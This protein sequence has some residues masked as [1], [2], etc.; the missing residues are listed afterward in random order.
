MNDDQKKAF[1]DYLTEHPE[2]FEEATLAMDNIIDLGIKEYEEALVRI[3]QEVLDDP[4]PIT[5]PEQAVRDKATEK[6]IRI[7]EKTNLLVSEYQEKLNSDLE[8]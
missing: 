2:K 5:N 8:K 1:T 4:N 6:K 3:Q 7:I